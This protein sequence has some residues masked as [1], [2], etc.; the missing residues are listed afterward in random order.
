[1]HIPVLYTE[2]L[3]A[4]QPKPG[5]VFIDATLG[6][7]GH[8]WGVLNASSPDGR[9]LGTD[10][11]F[12]AIER[13]TQRLREFDARVTLRQCWLDETPE[14]AVKLGF[15]KV[16]GILIDL[17]L[18]S[19]QLDEAQRGFSFMREGP[20]DM[21]FDTSKGMSAADWVNEADMASMAQVLR[22]YGDVANPMQVAEAICRARPL[23]TT[24]DL[25]QAVMSV[26]RVGRASRVNP[27]TL[28]FQALRIMVNDELRRLSQALPKYIEMLKPS[29]RLAVISFHSL[30]DGIVKRA[31]RDAA[32][33]HQAQFGFGSQQLVHEAQVTVMTKKPIQPSEAE[34]R[35][36]T[37][38]RS[39]RLRVV[40][41]I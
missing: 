39:A 30:E 24:L 6:G 2:V 4:L 35:E 31:F 41:R 28:V 1:M 36:N 11:D 33:T 7:A 18:S 3:D 14:L 27:A 29:G 10:A 34:C 8:A 20:L 37:R 26:A 5:G 38:A 12:A 16:D 23:H 17:G 40:E 19:F 21:R 25:R 9:L 13:C 22:E 32:E 15:A